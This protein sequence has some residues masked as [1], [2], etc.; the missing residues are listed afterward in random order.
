MNT[1]STPTADPII[2]RLEDQIRWYDEN[3]RLNKRYFKR[4]KT[5]E[6]VAAALIPLLSAFNF[7]HVVIVTGTLGGLITVLEGWL[8]LSQ[9]QQNWF[10]YRST[11]EQL[12]HEKY[13]YLGG[14][15][16]YATAADRRALLTERLEAL[17]S[18]EHT[19]WALTQTR[20]TKPKPA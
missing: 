7:A 13:F 6:I 2:E 15:G 17:V 10:T 12:K 19:N 18:Q 1:A 8:H 4:I 14:A 20:D 5:T 16:P 9:F 11:C 3:S